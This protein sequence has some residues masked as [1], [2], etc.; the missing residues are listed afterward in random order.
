M[1]RSKKRTI[2]ANRERRK[3]TSSPH[4]TLESL[5]KIFQYLDKSTLLRCAQVCKLW[6]TAAYSPNFWTKHI[7]CTKFGRL[8]NKTALSLKEREISTIC[9]E[10][11][12]VTADYTDD[13]TTSR[14]DILRGVGVAK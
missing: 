1:P 5:H 14:S 4:P 2:R 6:K 9:L 7:F 13:D 11:S 10:L 8:D 3:E 12:K